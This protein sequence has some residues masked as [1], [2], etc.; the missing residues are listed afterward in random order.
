M[1][2]TKMVNDVE[3]IR[4]K[5]NKIKNF[6]LNSTIDGKNYDEN[7]IED[8]LECDG[9]SICEFSGNKRIMN[10]V[11]VDSLSNYKKGKSIKPLNIKVNIRYF[12]NSLPEIVT[13]GINTSSKNPIIRICAVLII[14]KF[15]K[16]AMTV[17]IS[18]K[19]AIILIALWEK[20]KQE[21]EIFLEKG[22]EV[23]NSLCRKIDFTELEWEEYINILE[24]LEKM[25]CI[26]LI[27]EG[28]KLCENVSETYK[29]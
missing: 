26:R 22:F 10:K 9:F 2:N 20:R 14:C 23:A 8:I 3:I 15:I 13:A 19:Q 12:I 11:T 6:I 21:Q 1:R 27:D 24:E 7:I 4:R 17:P 28:I 25:G 29:I 5:K 18:K 16:C